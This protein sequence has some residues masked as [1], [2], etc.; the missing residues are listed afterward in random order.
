MLRHLAAAT[1]A[2]LTFSAA[3]ASAVTLQG[4]DGQP[5]GGQ[6]QQWADQ[7]L[8]PTSPATVEFSAD[9]AT[10][11]QH[12]EGAAYVIYTACTAAWT[13]QSGDGPTTMSSLFVGV[14][15]ASPA[16][17]YNPT[18]VDLRQNLYKEMGQVFDATVL[19]DQD[20]TAFIQIWRHT[21]RNCS[22]CSSSVQD[23][24]YYSPSGGESSYSEWFGQGWELCATF[25]DHLTASD[26]RS[27]EFRVGGGY[28]VQWADPH[29][30]RYSIRKGRFL[31]DRAR[32]RY[33][34]EQQTRVCQLIKNAAAHGPTILP[35]SSSLTSAQG[36]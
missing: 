7:A 33:A 12:C 5:V 10:I 1:L 9:A 2:A 27:A 17:H 6:W 16:E 21:H 20:R 32:Q 28:P 26:I 35:S 13:S 30:Y 15:P 22:Y 18:A 4:A 36:R 25:G 24:W 19:N 31:V 29:S 14:L 23:L 8:A 3:P 34:I 11:N